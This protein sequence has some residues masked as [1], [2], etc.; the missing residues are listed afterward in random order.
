MDDKK[1]ERWGLLG[2][3]EF[4]VLIL[5]AVFISGAPPD[6]DADPVEIG[7]WYLDNDTAIQLAAFLAGLALIAILWWFGSVWRHLRRAEDGEARLSVI[8]LLGLLMSGSLAFVAFALNSATAMR[9]EEVGAGAS[10]L[11]ASST[12]LYA[13]SSVGDVVLIA[14]VS[15]LAFRTKFLPDWLAWLGAGAAL[16]NLVG[17]IGSATDAAAI[18]VIGFIGFLLWLL[19]IA[20]VSVVLYQKSG[21]PAAA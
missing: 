21:A 10:V 19:W 20:A 1:W 14:A 11:Y 13:L 16:V 9:I 5:I 12:V 4:V 2:G 15:A 18:A 7:E 8:A 3:I 17:S 6:A